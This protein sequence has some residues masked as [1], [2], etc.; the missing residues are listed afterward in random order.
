MD[1]C[2]AGSALFARS[3]ANCARAFALGEAA[4]KQLNSSFSPDQSKAQPQQESMLRRPSDSQLIEACHRHAGDNDQQALL[5]DVDGTALKNNSES[6]N[7]WGQ[8][9]NRLTGRRFNG[10]EALS[11]KVE[12]LWNSTRW[13]TQGQKTGSCR[14]ILCCNLCVYRVCFCSLALLVTSTLHPLSKHCTT[15]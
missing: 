14:S 7:R 10:A 2:S 13:I 6:C 8:L 4:R 5:L 1:I 12:G 9:D 3:P 11:I 15:S